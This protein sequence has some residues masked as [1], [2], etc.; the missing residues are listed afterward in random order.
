M[1]ATTTFSKRKA[2][3]LPGCI[4]KG[5]LLTLPCAVALLLLSAF[6]A[7]RFPDPGKA[8]LPLGYGS[9]ALSS[10]LCGIFTGKLAGA[11][12]VGASVLAG[13]AEAVLLFL[14]S[15]ILG[16]QSPWPF[17]VSLLFYPAVVLLAACGGMLCN[18]KKKNR[19]YHR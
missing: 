9:V 13:V 16:A 1:N 18:R 19:R 10:L 4:L 3:P 11:G 7:L 15:L 8:V 6:A 5:L 12:A 2:S 17:P 14:L